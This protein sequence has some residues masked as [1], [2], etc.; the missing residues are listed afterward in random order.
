M[1]LTGITL[2]MEII[3]VKEIKQLIRELCN[4]GHLDWISQG[5]DP[6]PPSSLKI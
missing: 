3:S 4:N 5:H 2:N 6:L 1:R